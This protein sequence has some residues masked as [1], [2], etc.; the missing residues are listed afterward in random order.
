MLPKDEK[1][2]VCSK[3]SAFTADAHNVLRELGTNQILQVMRAAS[4]VHLN[5]KKDLRID[6]LFT[7]LS[8]NSGV[9]ITFINTRSYGNSVV[10]DL[11]YNKTARFAAI[12]SA[13]TVETL[14]FLHALFVVRKEPKDQNVTT[15]LSHHSGN[16]IEHCVQQATY[17]WKALG[18][19]AC[20]GL[21]L[22]RCTAHVVQ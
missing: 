7:T 8:L 21:V 22:S 15:S 11:Q 2:R 18:Q 19:A 12:S 10:D 20:V 4:V 5:T 1:R 16:V 9:P 13:T 3:D 17:V 14:W 6:E